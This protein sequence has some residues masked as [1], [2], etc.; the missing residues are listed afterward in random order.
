VIVAENSAQHEF[1]SARTAIQ[2]VL[3]RNFGGA[4]LSCLFAATFEQ[5]Q[6][7]MIPSPGSPFKPP[8]RVILT[9]SKREQWLKDLS[10]VAVP[11]QWLNRTIPHGVRGRLLLHQCLNKH[12][13]I[14][15]AVWLIKCV[16]SNETR[17]TRR[18]GSKASIRL[19][20]SIRWLQEFTGYVLTFL[21]HLFVT[22]TEHQ[23][24]QQVEYVVLLTRRVFLEHLVDKEC[25]WEGLAG[26][27]HQATH[28]HEILIYLEIV[29]THW[30][31]TF[32]LRR[33]SSPCLQSL[34]LQISRVSP[35]K[36]NS[37]LTTNAN[38]SSYH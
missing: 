21:R 37:T 27:I 34:L 24:G 38:A 22:P 28:I 30:K 18:K 25:F 16:A 1:G 10:N 12:I 33:L 32:E 17:A 13:P 8:P 3:K 26:L 7:S 31:E 14:P 2:D 15:R 11:M 9:D 35:P 5:R 20:S 6:T 23:W 4:A 36:V 29:K 19:L